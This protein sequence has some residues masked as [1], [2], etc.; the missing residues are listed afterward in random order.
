MYITFKRMVDD[1]IKPDA[2]E[3]LDLL[4]SVFLGFFDFVQIHE[5]EERRL[6]DFLTVEALRGC[7]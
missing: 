7:S 1:L 4:R 6:A 2:K 3:T 5:K